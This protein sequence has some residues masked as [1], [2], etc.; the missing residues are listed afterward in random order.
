VPAD[1]RP[2]RAGDA[3]RGGR[4]HRCRGAVAGS[5]PGARSPRGCSPGASS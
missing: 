3:R 1:H 5:P 2:R 4:C